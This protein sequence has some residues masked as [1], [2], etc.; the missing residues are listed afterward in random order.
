MAELIN[1]GGG[2][3]CFRI[4]CYG[5]GLVREVQDWIALSAMN[6]VGPSVRIRNSSLSLESAYRSTSR[7]NW[8]LW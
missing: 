3:G 7:P 8:L 6:P 2:A 5:A 1:S 4:Q